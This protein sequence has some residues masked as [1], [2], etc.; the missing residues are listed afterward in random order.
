MKNVAKS[1]AVSV[2]EGWA[3]GEQRSEE[4]VLKSMRYIE[5]LLILL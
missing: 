3:G 2:D 5:Y 1:S 4:N